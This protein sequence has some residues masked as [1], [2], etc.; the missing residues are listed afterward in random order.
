MKQKTLK[1]SFSVSGKGLYYGHVPTGPRKSR[2]QNTTR[3]P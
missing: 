2:I 3:R 1:N